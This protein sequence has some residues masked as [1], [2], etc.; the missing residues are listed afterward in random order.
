MW[1]P[2]HNL[3]KKIQQR[4]NQKKCQR[5]QLLYYKT[6]TECPH[7]TGIDDFKLK[8]LLA[9]RARFRIGL[10]KGMFIAAVVIMVLLFWINQL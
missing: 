4:K 8:K 5:C 2:Y 7:C 10:G 3:G 6:L 1:L 9:K